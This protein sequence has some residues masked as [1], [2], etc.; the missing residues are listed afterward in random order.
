MTESGDIIDEKNEV[1]HAW[2]YNKRLF[3]SIA[4][5]FDSQGIQNPSFEED[6]EES[7]ED[8]RKQSSI[9]RAELAQFTE[10]LTYSWRN[11]NVW[12]PGADP[13]SEDDDPERGCCKRSKKTS[14]HILKNCNYI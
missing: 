14:K 1:K 3:K 12:T 5:A 13:K 2:D 9:K 8:A 7:V 11:L 4:P 6:Y 10:E